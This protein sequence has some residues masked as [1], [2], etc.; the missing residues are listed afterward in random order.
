M[1]PSSLIEYVQEHEAPVITV[2]VDRTNANNRFG[3]DPYGSGR[4]S[5]QITYAYVYD[6]GLSDAQMSVFT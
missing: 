5:A 2:P 3:V 1:H 6:S 4:L